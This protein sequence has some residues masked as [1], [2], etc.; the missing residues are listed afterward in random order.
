ME[1]I[2]PT[3]TPKSQREFLKEILQAAYNT[4]CNRQIIYP[5]LAKNLDKLDENFTTIF[6]DWAAKELSKV[7]PAGIET[8]WTAIAVGELSTLIS[9]FPLGNQSVNLEIAIVGYEISLTVFTYEDFPLQWATLQNK[10]GT[11]Y[12][13]RIGGD[14]A[15]NLEL[16]IACYH[17]ALAV[18][19]REGYPL[20]WA[21]IN[22][23]LGAVYSERIREDKAKNLEL[24]IAYYHAALEVYTRENYPPEW[25]ATQNNLGTAYSERIREDKAENLE[26]A[27]IC[28]HAALEV[29]TRENYPLDWAATQNNLG[30][31]YANRLKG[32]KAENLELAIICYHAALEVR[33]RESYPLD[34]AATQNNLGLAYANRLEGDKS[35]NVERAID[36]YRAAL[37]VRTRENY[38]LQWGTTQNNLGAA[39]IDRI[40][41]DRAE[42]YEMAISLYEG[43]L[44]VYTNQNSPIEWAR[45]NNNL[46]T[47]YTVRIRENK[48]ANIEKAIKCYGFALDVYS[49]ETSPQDWAMTQNNLGVAY[50]HRIQSDKAENLENAIACYHAALMVYNKRSF[51][52]DWATAQYNLGN[53]Y[54]DRI[55]DDKA[56][57][58]EIA[59]EFYENALSVLSRE[60][61]RTDWAM[62]QDSLGIAYLKRI[63]G[64][65][66]ENLVV[67]IRY[68]KSALEVRTRE[69][70]P[71]C[72]ISTS[73]GLG[74]AYKQAKQFNNAYDIFASAIDTVESLRE[75]IISGNESKQKLSEEWHCIYLNMVE[76]CLALEKITTAIE[77]AERSK[78]RNLIENILSRDLRT[79]FPLEVV[80]TLEELRDKIASCQYQLQNGRAKNPQDMV[81]HLRQLRQQKNQLQD[82]YLPVGYGFNLNEFQSILDEATA[83]VELYITNAGL[84]IFIIS[85]NIIQRISSN[86]SSESLQA[87]EDWGNKYLTTYRQDRKNWEDN[88]AANLKKLANLLNIEEIIAHEAIKKCSRLILIPHRT[89]H[90]FPLHALPLTDG[91]FLCDKFSKGIGY[92]PSCQLL[93]L[94]QTRKRP[95][96]THLFAL[97][98]PRQDRPY[99]D[100]GI[101]VIR[102]H[103]QPNDYVL[104]GEKATKAN[105]FHS[106]QLH[107]THCF[108]F[109][110]HGV[111]KFEESYL[112]LAD[113]NLTLREIFALDLNQCRLVILSACETGMT[114]FNSISDEYIGLSSGFLLAGSSS[115]V[116][117]LWEVDQLSV[118]FLMIEFYENLR[119]YEQLEE[120]DIAIALNQAQKR[121]RDLTNDEFE[122]R[123][124]QYKPLIDE[125]LG[126][127]PKGKRRV[128]EAS[129]KQ[130]QSQASPFANPYDWAAFTA[131]G[132]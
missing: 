89:L 69:D 57:N 86:T 115:V 131:T 106:K 10:L 5:L 22:N 75:E 38:Q 16:A 70:F 96:F 29:R 93:Q 108:H 33:I 12:G 130:F 100:L 54:C 28:Y 31:A 124:T 43:A 32:D 41:G 52:V 63:R 79:I 127:L 121:L 99:I 21:M 94:A 81:K 7:K 98:N 48:S 45:I 83:I 76:I 17:S 126:K 119:N 104:S 103:F 87:L 47:A 82:K 62:L 80:G 34:W 117:T 122:Q 109:F 84:E 65:R 128:A 107:S 56:E 26:L 51:P 50:R 102:P 78:N 8:Q 53:I 58:L 77:Y 40:V 111:F 39:Y 129:I 13:K 101:E 112:E 25:A 68:Y 67:A 37:E 123:L 4:N 55:E 132:I 18:R 66:A 11:V 95:N 36:C 116:S 59:I 27:I 120:G 15:E 35:D 92:A 44:T 74:N 23:N 114:D 91:E 3:P 110:G 113:E 73:F 71:Q 61:F 1:F 2:T 85:S 9:N 125:I 30:L 42:N 46:G 49:L 64:E 19:T 72:Y 60:N 88:L 105:L 6:Q 14:R 20:D 118:A 90:L 24:A 97:Q